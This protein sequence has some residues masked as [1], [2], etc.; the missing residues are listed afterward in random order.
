MGKKQSSSISSRFETRRNAKRP[1][2]AGPHSKK[3][4]IKNTRSLRNKELKH[5]ELQSRQ[6]K[7]KES[8]KESTINSFDALS[9]VE[10][11][12][13]ASND[14]VNTISEESS[15]DE[16]ILIDSDEEK[17][18]PEVLEVNSEK[19][20]DVMEENQEFIAFDFTDDHEDE[21][22]SD[23]ESS[24]GEKAAVKVP[25]SSVSDDTKKLP[26]QVNPNYPWLRNNNHTKQLEVSDWLTMEI[27]DFIK[28]ISPS[29]EEIEARNGVV[30][31]LSEAISELWPDAEL[32]CFGSYATD[33]YLPGSD[34][35]TVIIS[36]GRKYDNKSALYQLS[37]FLR[38]HKLGKCIETIAK[39]KVPIIK[40]IDPR[41]GFHID[42]SFE[43]DNGVSAA[44]IIIS[45][46]DSTPGL[47]E[48]VMIVKQF[49]AVRRLNEVHTGG[50]GGFAIICLA[51][52]FLS[53]H[54]RII[55]KS[56][57]PLQNLGVLLI[58]FFELY[59][60]NFGYDE[61]AIAFKHKTQASYISKRSNPNLLSNNPFSLAIQDPQDPDNNISRGT[62]NLRDIKRS[63]GGAYEMLVNKCYEM[64]QATYKQRLGQSILGDIIK[65]QGKARDFEDARSATDNHAYQ[66]A[67][68]QVSRVDLLSSSSNSRASSVSSLVT[69]SAEREPSIE[70]TSDSSESD[71]VSESKSSED[72]MK[73]RAL[74]EKSQ[75]S[76]RHTDKDVDSIMGFKKE[77]ADKE[78]DIYDPSRGTK[79]DHKDF[80]DSSD[81]MEYDPSEAPKN[82]VAK[83]KR[84]E[85]WLQKG[86][87]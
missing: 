32:H 86:G 82:T 14:V 18:S 51:Y 80:E 83:D 6:I 58:E 24:S 66:I 65:Y 4:H 40:F 8:S 20:H 47:R 50:L 56:I 84:R 46:I 59:G 35:D 52:S 63:F 27:K 1:K 75:S 23:I 34:I 57:D 54:P 72:G 79:E 22:E 10:S 13:D 73:L 11:S 12:R 39:A 53:L 21:V 19:E 33:M 42:I 15:G 7:V 30:H 29:K 37:S 26:K 3:L 36:K 67:S 68:G 87:L 74:F 25:I 60:F 76:S 16:I 77:E 64:N 9:K 41:T 44:K 45:W 38:T 62:F 71:S 31:R 17:S 61:I 55:T 2:I 43:R 5:I 70:Y 48:L 69:A 78:D 85:Y 81:D 49:L 28:Y